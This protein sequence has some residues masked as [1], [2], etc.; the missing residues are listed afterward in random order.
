MSHRLLLGDRIRRMILFIREKGLSHLK[1]ID[2]LLSLWKPWYPAFLSLD[3]FT[4]IYYWQVHLI[5][6]DT[7]SNENDRYM[8]LVQTYK[9]E[10]PVNLVLHEGSNVESIKVAECSLNRRQKIIM[11]LCKI[12]YKCLYYKPFRVL[13]WWFY[14]KRKVNYWLFESKWAMCHIIG[15]CIPLFSK[16]SMNMF[17]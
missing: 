9:N 6:V 12:K 4:I 3:S 10:L 14:V 16:E 5:L 11:I 2:N 7:T 13:I 1:C 17:L 15:M 8:C